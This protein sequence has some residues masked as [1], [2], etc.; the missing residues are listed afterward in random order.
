MDHYVD[1]TIRSD[2]DVGVN[3]M[4]GTLFYKLHVWLSENMPNRVGLCF[5]KMALTPGDCLRLHG[6]ETDLKAVIGGN[7]RYSL[8]MFIQMQPVRPIPANVQ[9][10]TVQRVQRKSVHNRRLRSIRKG[11]LNETE[12]VSRI[13]GDHDRRLDL[14]FIVVRSH[15]SQQVIKIFIRQQVRF[16]PVEGGFTSYGLSKDGSTV[17]WF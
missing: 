5:P 10:C 17:P 14:P 9:F 8:L 3:Q 1:V 4:M 12:V 15:S 6:T 13:P 11:W 16:E 2:A 7:W